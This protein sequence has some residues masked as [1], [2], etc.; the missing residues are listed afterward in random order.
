M[1]VWSL[2]VVPCSFAHQKS[3]QREVLVIF[4]KNAQVYASAYLFLKHII[5]LKQ[6]YRMYNNTIQNNDK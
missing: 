6:H 2:L 3:K 1:L 5:T 4:E